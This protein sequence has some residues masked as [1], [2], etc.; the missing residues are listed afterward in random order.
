M[1]RCESIDRAVT[2]GVTVVGLAGI[3]LIHLLD[4]SGKMKETP[5]L[6][7]GYVALIVGTVVAG[8]LLLRVETARAGFVLAGALAAATIVGYAVNRTVG[9][10]SATEDIGNWLEPLGLASLFVEG[11][12]A[13]LGTYGVWL[14]GRRADRRDVAVAV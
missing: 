3:A 11:V 5:Y 13:M 4:L 9:I 1:P 14:S 7:W 12:V 8:A 10:P 2:R 6:G